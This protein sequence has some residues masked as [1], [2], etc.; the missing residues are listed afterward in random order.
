MYGHWSEPSAGTELLG[1]YASFHLLTQTLCTL[2]CLGSPLRLQHTSRCSLVV[3]T[4]HHLESVHESQQSIYTQL[5]RHVQQNTLSRLIQFSEP[6][7]SCCELLD[8]VLNVVVEK[9]I[10]LVLRQT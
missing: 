10:H 8:S 9:V 6:R 2:R 5:K 1:P 4:L 3:T 7:Q